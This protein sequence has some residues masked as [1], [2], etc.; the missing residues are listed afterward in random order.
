MNNTPHTHTT[1]IEWLEALSAPL[2][3][4][5]CG[6]DLKYEE[7]FKALKASSSGVG[8]VDFKVMFIQASD[9]LNT[10]S[11]DLRIVSYLALAATSEFGVTGLTHTLLLFKRLLNGI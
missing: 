4:N 7:T 9:L 2:P 8:E 11:K 10:Q 3:G 6:E 1:W 5:K